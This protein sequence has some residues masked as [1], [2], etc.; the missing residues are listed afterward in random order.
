[1]FVQMSSAG[2]Q[3]SVSDQD[4]E[5]GKR[6]RLDKSESEIIKRWKSRVESDAKSGDLVEAQL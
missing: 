2:R 4:K 6:K 3:L 1:M 5:I